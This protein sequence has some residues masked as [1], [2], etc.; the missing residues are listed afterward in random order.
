MGHTGSDLHFTVRTLCA[1]LAGFCAM[2][3]LRICSRATDLAL[4]VLLMATLVD[5]A[6]TPEAFG[7]RCTKA[8]V[9]PKEVTAV[10]ITLCVLIGGAR[11]QRGDTIWAFGARTARAE[12]FS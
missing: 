8:M 3:L 10:T 1:F 12:A 7:A 4:R 9:S 11:G 6:V 5:C 2:M